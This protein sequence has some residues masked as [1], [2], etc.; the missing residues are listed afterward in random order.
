MLSPSLAP[1]SPSTTPPGPIKVSHI[2]MARRPG[3]SGGRN[4]I[5]PK[6]GA[7]LGLLK[8]WENEHIQCDN[9]ASLLIE[10]NTLFTTHASNVLDEQKNA[11]IKQPS[12]ADANSNSVVPCTASGL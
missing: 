6:I 1:E 7:L 12:A 9:H 2:I 8:L 10:G 5:R 4:A 11:T 3:R